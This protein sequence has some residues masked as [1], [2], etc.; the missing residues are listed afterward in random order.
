MANVSFKRG[1]YS[2]SVVEQLKDGELFF[3]TSAGTANNGI[4]MGY[5]DS[6][7]VTSGLHVGIGN[8]QYQ[9]MIDRA[10]LRGK[11]FTKLSDTDNGNMYMFTDPD[12]NTGV[13]YVPT[14]YNNRAG[15]GLK[16]GLRLTN[17]AGQTGVISREI[18]NM[19]AGESFGGKFTCDGWSGGIEDFKE[20]IKTGGNTKT[21]DLI[22]FVT[23]GYLSVSAYDTPNTT[24]EVT[25]IHHCKNNYYIEYLENGVVKNIKD[26]T[27]LFINSSGAVDGTGKQNRVGVIITGKTE[28]DILTAAGTTINVD[29][30]SPATLTA[31]EVEAIWDAA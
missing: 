23:P 31:E 5:T 24:Y 9:Y 11:T 6:T 28:K 12:K 2:K 3:D 17:S 25:G 30:I 4:Y 16:A 26:F 14:F 21:P 13:I 10:F 1:I 27:G 8:K 19:W 29:T 22:S 15:I 7:G 20:F 18:A